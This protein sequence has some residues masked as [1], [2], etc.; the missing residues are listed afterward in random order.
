MNPES[1][2][3]NLTRF[4]RLS[5]YKNTK[6]QKL[7]FRPFKN[8]ESLKTGYHTV[9]TSLVYFKAACE[10]KSLL[11]LSKKNLNINLQSVDPSI[12]NSIIVQHIKENF[13]LVINGDIYEF[14]DTLFYECWNKEYYNKPFISETLSKSFNKI[15]QKAGISRNLL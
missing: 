12:M 3:M 13:H 2:T 14:D 8:K 10:N 15:N 6:E 9:L 7:E 4:K 11:F 5:L 1:K